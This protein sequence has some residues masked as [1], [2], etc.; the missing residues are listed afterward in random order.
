MAVPPTGKPVG[1]P[2]RNFMTRQ[3][4]ISALGAK[5]SED[6]STAE[7]LSQTQYYQGYFDGEM[8]K[9]K[10]E[11]EIADE[12]GDPLLIAKTIVESPRDSSPFGAS[13]E[14]Q[15]ASYYEGA[16]Q[17][18]HQ[19]SAEELKAEMDAAREATSRKYREAQERAMQHEADR[20]AASSYGSYGSSSS[21]YGGSYGGDSSSYGGSYGG[22]SS[23]YGG[24]YEGSG[25]SGGGDNNG[26]S[27]GGGYAYQEAPAQEKTTSSSFDQ[28]FRQEKDDSEVV[29]G[30]VEGKSKSS[31]MRDANGDFNWGLLALILGLIV[32]FGG[33]AWFVGK[34]IAL[35]GPFLLVLIIIYFVARIF[36]KD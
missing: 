18:E 31:L 6:L 33:L 14:D 15:Q 9:G 22:G 8:K 34:L 27:Y 5:L 23:S 36:R 35:L 30:T 17:G 3:E 25:S 21:S 2:A 1:F 11:E 20:K 16:F 19:K 12:L 10:T 7:V 4:F 26:A 24:S 28:Q 29:R 32:I 13:Y